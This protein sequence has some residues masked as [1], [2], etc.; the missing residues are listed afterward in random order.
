MKAT[1]PVTDAATSHTS[2]SATRDMLH[3]TNGKAI[4]PKIRDAGIGGRIVPWEDALHEGP[5]PAGL[6]VA[7][8][9]SVR[10]DFLAACGWGRREELAREIEHRDEA[11]NRAAAAAQEIVLWFEHDLYDQLHLLQI[12][13]RL[14]VD[15]P[16]R[17]TAV[18]PSTYLGHQ[19]NSDY[20]GLFEQRR[21]VTSNERMTARDA[22]QAFRSADPRTILAALPRLTALPHL[23]AA[24]VRHLQQ[25]PAVRNGVSRT[26][27][28][29]L[30]A[31]TAGA[32]RLEDAF[33]HAI[34]DR[35]EAMFMSDAAFLFHISS[36]FRG[37]RPLVA[38]DRALTPSRVEAPDT[39][40]LSVALTADGKR[41]LGGELDRVQ[42]CG[43]DRWLGGVHLVGPGPVWRWDGERRELRFV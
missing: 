10:A 35:E 38:I 42:L 22:W 18:S 17:I 26:E 23:G 20:P 27:Q 25:F 39:L 2:A 33:I 6:G 30:E 5:V 31:L 40:T 15:G 21:A 9:G 34:C 14:P 4:I 28:Q 29:T 11:L 41:V 43:I 36:L 13:D 7:A 8:L 24:M 32:T 1:L 12:L 37:P 16:P 19:A 3:L